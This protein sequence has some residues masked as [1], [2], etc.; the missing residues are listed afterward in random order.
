MGTIGGSTAHADPAADYPAALFALE[1]KF[2]L[3]KA[4]SERTVPVEEFFVDTF[5]TRSNRAN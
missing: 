2:E 1:A 5:T 4:G 3:V